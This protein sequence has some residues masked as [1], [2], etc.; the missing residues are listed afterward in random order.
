VTVVVLV[1]AWLLVAVLVALV[2]GHA[3]GGKP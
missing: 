2:I 3:A 1:V